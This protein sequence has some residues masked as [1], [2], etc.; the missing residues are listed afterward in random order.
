VYSVRINSNEMINLTIEGEKWAD[1]RPVLEILV[2]NYAAPNVD[3]Y[4]A[5]SAAAGTEEDAPLRR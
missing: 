2:G 4:D 3:L 1:V 5:P